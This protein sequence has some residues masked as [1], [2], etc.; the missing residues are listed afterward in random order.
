LTKYNNKTRVYT[1][2]M[3]HLSQSISLKNIADLMRA[4]ISQRYNPPISYFI[5]FVQ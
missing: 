2:P 5:P 1:N 3:S 4:F